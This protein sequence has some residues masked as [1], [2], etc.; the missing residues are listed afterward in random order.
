MGN[1]Q[2]NNVISKLQNLFTHYLNE[3][4]L[5]IKRDLICNDYRL[6]EISDFCLQLNVFLYIKYKMSR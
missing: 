6:S 5:E 1:I 3:R 4:L 2:S